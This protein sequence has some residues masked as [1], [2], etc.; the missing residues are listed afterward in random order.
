ME[1][2]NEL[3]EQLLM[4][5]LSLEMKDV[6]IDFQKDGL[7]N[8]NFIVSHN[9]MKYAVRISGDKASHLGIRR[10]AEYA[11]MKEV[12]SL[13]LGHWFS[14]QLLVQILLVQQLIT[15]EWLDLYSAE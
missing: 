13:R 5:Q 10:N 3:L 1:D 7:T 12:E 11:A 14:L 4:Q 6:T 8:Q 9:N 2:T 15:R